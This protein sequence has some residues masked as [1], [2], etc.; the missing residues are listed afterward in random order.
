MKHIHIDLHFVRD[1][2]QYGIIN[3][4]HVNTHDQ[5]VDLL[6]KAL[7]R[8]RTKILRDKIGLSDGSSILQR[9]I[10]KGSSNHATKD[11]VNP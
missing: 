6:A 2:V 10:T 8:Q 3:V 1:M 5:L 4:H 7:S 11:I 9:C